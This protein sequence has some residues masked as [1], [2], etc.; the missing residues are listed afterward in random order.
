MEW[1][2]RD[3]IVGNKNSLYRIIVS[4]DGKEATEIIR[5]FLEGIRM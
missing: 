5:S 3:S 1:D 2:E 4:F